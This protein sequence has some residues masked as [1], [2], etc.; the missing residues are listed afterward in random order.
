LTAEERRLRR[1]VRQLRPASRAKA[2]L[3]LRHTKFVNNWD[4]V[5]CS[6]VQI[7]GAHLV[8]DARTQLQHLP[9][10]PTI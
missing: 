3:Y 6:A 9:R 8:G 4:L 5:D 10:T 1:E 2:N 7:V